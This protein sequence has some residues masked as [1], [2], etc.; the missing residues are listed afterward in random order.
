MNTHR[1]SQL[2][3]AMLETTHAPPFIELPRGV[4]AL[5]YARHF[6]ASF[7]NK[8]TTCKRATR[9]VLGTV[10]VFHSRPSKAP[11]RVG[12][13]VMADRVLAKLG[14]DRVS[15]LCE[16]VNRLNFLFV[17]LCTRSAK[18]TD[19]T[20]TACKTYKACRRQTRRGETSTGTP[21][22]ETAA[23]YLARFGAGHATRHNP[24][25]PRKGRRRE[26]RTHG[27]IMRIECAAGRHAPECR[28]GP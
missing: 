8:T 13:A 23:R 28:C 16:C 15:T 12:N 1:A 27:R 10:A 19:A 18:R 17:P 11:G 6:M 20:F 22:H 26:R 21:R 14:Q 3:A 24:R 9:H 2:L 5:Y 25:E 7:P 4:L